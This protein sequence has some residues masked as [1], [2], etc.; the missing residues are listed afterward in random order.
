[1]VFS[2][3]SHAAAPSHGGAL[4]I[5]SEGE[6][7]N[8]NP[9]LV[10][11]ASGQP[12]INNIF[13][14]LI[15]MNFKFEIIPGLARSW[16]V[17]KDGLTYTFRLARN[18]TWHDGKP[19]TS[20]DVLYTLNEVYPQNPRGA[21]WK[22]GE[23]VFPSAPDPYTFVIRLKEPFAP[24]LTT[25]AFQVTGPNI[26]PKHLYEGTDIKKNPHNSK[27]VGTGP[28]MFK[29]WI[30]GSHIELVRNPNYFAKGKENKPYIDRLVFRTVPDSSARV[31][32]LK[33]GEIDF[34]PSTFVPLEDLADLRKDKNIVIDRRGGGPETIKFLLFNLRQP[35]LSNKLVR[36]AVAYA[37]DKNAISNLA[38]AG[39][40][41]MAK[42]ILTA[43]TVWAYNPKVADY[44]YNVK[45][46][47][48]LLDKAGYPKAA[49]G[50][51]FKV[52]LATIAGRGSDP[53]VIEVIQDCLKKVGIDAQMST[54]ELSSFY[55]AVFMRWDFDIVLQQAATGPDPTAGVSRFLHSKQIKKATFVNAMAYSNPEVDKLLDMEYKQTDKKQRAATWQKIQQIVLDDLPVMPIYESIVA[56]AYRANWADIVTTLY[57]TAQS[58]EDAY[59]K[60]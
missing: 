32:A 19:F 60:K 47:N 45:K 20:A 31:L 30:K 58:R 50:T 36:Q 51:R 46:A 56:N 6:E 38:L 34:I 52:R 23:N 17:S 42:S 22:P 21:W 41:K 40:A 57:G 39:E 9:H 26:L 5:A 3:E 14:L 8:L 59:M 2:C 10:T 43:N 27:P 25:L 48:E 53:A 7:A 24:L 35:P 16:E 37:I 18:V 11:G 13:N 4:L 54:M 49:D 29:E 28:F 1:M 33:K 12:V 44:T 15:Y 55:D